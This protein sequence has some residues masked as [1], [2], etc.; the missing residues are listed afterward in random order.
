MSNYIHIQLR[1]RN[2]INLNKD[3]NKN[4]ILEIFKLSTGNSII[5]SK[6]PYISN[7]YTLSNKFIFKLKTPPSQCNLKRTFEIIYNKNLIK[8]K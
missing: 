5:N 3:K 2:L 1:N 8:K 7:K 4:K 6:Y